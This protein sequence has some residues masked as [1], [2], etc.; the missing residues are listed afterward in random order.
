MT[1]PIDRASA[2]DLAFLA[3]ER[4]AVP[5]QIGAVLVLA[6]G[7]AVDL[8][9]VRRL[10]A[11]RV[12]AIP[13]L[14]QRLVRV[15]PGC[16]RPVWVDDPDFDVRRHVRC[17]PCRYPGDEQALLDTAAAVVAERL[18][19]SRPLWTVVLLT[20]P[21]GGAVALLVVLHRSG[22]ARPAT[23]PSASW[24]CPT[25]VP[26]SSPR[27]PTPTTSPT[28]RGSSRRCAPNSIC[29]PG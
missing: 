12:A 10:F 20:G 19:R 15:P 16:G 18:P 29:S 8:T 28:C 5:E 27:S 14:R 23:S 2:T 6:P 11:E 13:R 25:P 21:A 4:G 17:A 26:S 3:M 22:S 7:T 24:S 1:E 9:G